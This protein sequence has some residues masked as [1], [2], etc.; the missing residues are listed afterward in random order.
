MASLGS[1]FS[2][3]KI[4]KREMQGKALIYIPIK[5]DMHLDKTSFDRNE[6]IDGHRRH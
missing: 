4:I 3:R 2:V 5:F 1:G 6:I